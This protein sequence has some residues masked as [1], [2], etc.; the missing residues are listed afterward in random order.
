MHE[1]GSDF[2]QNDSFSMI[3]DDSFESDTD[4]EHGEE[5][6]TQYSRGTLGTDASDV[7]QMPVMWPNQIS[8]RSTCWILKYPTSLTEQVRPTHTL[9]TGVPCHFS[10]LWSS[11]RTCM[12][13]SGT[14]DW[15]PT[16]VDSSACSILWA[17]ISS[18]CPPL[19]PVHNVLVYQQIPW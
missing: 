6:A 17:S 19:A 3:S 18:Q 13:L 15:E 1:S 8:G 7:A 9:Q 16:A 12:R 4:S 10:R 5:D 2:D 14:S 11:K